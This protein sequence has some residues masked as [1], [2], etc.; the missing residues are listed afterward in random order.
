M[1][2]ATDYDRLARIHRP[3]DP[4][5]LAMEMRRLHSNGLT[6]RD[7]SVALRLSIG[8]V[9]ESL[10]APNSPPSLAADAP[11]RVRHAVAGDAGRSFSNFTKGQL[12]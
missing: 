4:A 3:S 11:L 6:P 10:A 5:V 9:L 12:T 2:A 1:T 8:Q 7:I